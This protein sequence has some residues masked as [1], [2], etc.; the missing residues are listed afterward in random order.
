MHVIVMCR[1]R[2]ERMR[3]G[4]MTLYPA[5]SVFPFAR[6]LKAITIGRRLRADIVTTQDPFESGLAGYIVARAIGAALHVQVHTDFLSPTY[7]RH[8]LLNHARAAIAG[9]VLRRARRIR[10][11]SE[12]IKR[13]IE[14]RYKL[15]APIAT[16]PIYTD[17]SRVDAPEMERLREKFAAFS[18]KILVVSRLEPEKNVARAVSS[19][20]AASPK[21]TCLIIVGRGSE[22]YT[23]KKLAE[24]LCVRDRVFFEGWRDPIAYYGLADLVLVSSE[25]EGY[26]LV[27]VEA[28]GRGVP[29]ISTDVGIAREAGAIIAE[30]ARFQ[31]ALA[32]WFRNG[33]REGR[34]NEYPYKNF[35]DYVRAYCDDIAVAGENCTS[36]GRAA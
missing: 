14:A 34:L 6:A 15:R 2:Y 27:V 7:S 31:K 3:R 28:L 36:R 9:F 18:K 23:L 20:A 21:D 19:F 30:P 29:V 35:D 32:D 24:T 12:R 11:V 1:G 25:Y 10:V 4:N 13:S 17:I 16:L 22:A 8:S 26:G 33:P 5:S